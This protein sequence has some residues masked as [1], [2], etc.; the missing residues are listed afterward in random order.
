MSE[1]QHQRERIKKSLLFHPCGKTV[2]L[3]IFFALLL[4]LSFVPRGFG[5]NEGNGPVDLTQVP[6][7]VG[8]ALGI[9]EPNTALVGGLVVGM[10]LFLA[11]TLPSLL[12]PNHAVS[13]IFGFLALALNGALGWWPGWI[14][15]IST[16]LISGMLA[17]Q[18]LK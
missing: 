18:I 2:F 9:P 14:L 7:K 4:V 10:I 13:L 16:L 5:E 15:L 17:R 8:E 12:L 1:K 6:Q 11:I 3:V